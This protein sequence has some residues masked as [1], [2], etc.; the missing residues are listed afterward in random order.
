M[1][2]KVFYILFFVSVLANT[3]SCQM[4]NKSRYK[5]CNDIIITENIFSLIDT[6]QYYKIEYLRTGYNSIS[7]K[8]SSTGKIQFLF[9][10]NENR[11]KNTPKKYER[12]SYYIGNRFLILKTFVKYPQGGIRTKKI[13]TAVCDGILYFRYEDECEKSIRLTPINVKYNQQ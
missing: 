5:N 1:V 11:Y 10:D 4:M 6:T 3:F 7:C 9:L 12:G 13:L 2:R 8:F